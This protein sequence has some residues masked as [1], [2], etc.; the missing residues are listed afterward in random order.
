MGV[1]AFLISF[2]VPF[3][4]LATVEAKISPQTAIK[5]KCFRNNLEHKMCDSEKRTREER[6][7]ER[8]EKKRFLKS[9]SHFKG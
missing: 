9:N 4:H 6:L 7:K 3:I 1:Q 2:M 5:P 8:G